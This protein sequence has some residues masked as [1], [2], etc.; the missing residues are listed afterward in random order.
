MLKSVSKI[1]GSTIQ[2]MDGDIGKITEVYFDDEKW[3]VRYLIV[4]T[5]TWLAERKVLISPYSVMQPMKT[6]GT[7]RLMLTRDQVKNSPDIDTHQPISRRHERDFFNYYR[8]PE[9]WAG[10]DLWA[11]GGFPFMPLIPEMPVTPMPVPEVQVVMPAADVHLRSSAHVHGY[12][13]QASDGSIGHVM[14]FIFDD[15]SWA[16]RYLI[17]DTR[18]WWPGGKKVLISQQWIDEISW[19]RRHVSVHMTR[20]QVKLAPEFDETLVLDREY[21]RKLYASYERPGY[22][23]K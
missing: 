7:I 17:V 19:E 16:L 2:A 14:D 12:D 18:N 11:L 13:I 6:E 3:A 9:Y 15:E 10:N 1:Q 8:Y 5:G 21:E 23:D 4:D 20:E 22:W